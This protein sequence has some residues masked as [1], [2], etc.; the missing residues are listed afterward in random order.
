MVENILENSC[1]SRLCSR[2]LIR[3]CTGVHGMRSRHDIVSYPAYLCNAIANIAGE[4]IFICM[5]ALGQEFTPFVDGGALV[6]H[7]NPSLFGGA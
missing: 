2:R 7:D 4:D 1:N 6:T 5:A 3:G